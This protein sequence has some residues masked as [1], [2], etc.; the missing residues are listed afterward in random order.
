MDGFCYMIVVS[1]EKL[2]IR[3]FGKVVW[4]KET[5]LNK[6]PDKLM[7]LEGV[8]KSVENNEKWYF[9]D[10]EEYTMY[11]FF[12]NIGTD[13]HPL[14]E[15][16]CESIWCNSNLGG[17]YLIGEEKNTGAFFAPIPD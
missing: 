8:R 6:L 16:S 10:D 5:G 7:K 14:I 12:A 15:M 9:Y 4:K 13:E 2:K 3:Q 1:E 11:V 17:V